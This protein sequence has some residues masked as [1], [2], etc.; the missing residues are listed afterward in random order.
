MTEENKPLHF[1]I[2][3]VCILGVVVAGFF[4]IYIG[5][6]I[7][8]AATGSSIT[9]SITTS[10]LNTSASEEPIVLYF[11]LPYV[12]DVPALPSEKYNKI[13]DGWTSSIV[14][15][16]YGDMLSLTA[17]TFP[18]KDIQVTFRQD[19][20]S[21]AEMFLSDR[22]PGAFGQLNLLP[23]ASNLHSP[24]TIFVDDPHVYRAQ[25]DADPTLIYLPDT[26]HS[27]DV[28][29]L[30]LM[31][32]L[33]TPLNLN[34]LLAGHMTCEAIQIHEHIPVD[35]ISGFI[36]VT[37]L[38]P[39]GSLPPKY[40]PIEINPPKGSNID[41]FVLFQIGTCVPGYTTHYDYVVG[42]NTTEL[43]VALTWD[44]PTYRMNLNLISPDGYVL[45]PYTDQYD[46]ISNGII[47]LTIT[48]RLSSAGEWG[49]EVSGGEYPD[50]HQQ[51][52]L[53][54]REY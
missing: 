23:Q 16:E 54:V 45:G 47:P 48:S 8:A 33:F 20:I 2:V 26:I 4:S 36:P 34:K 9:Y 42:T 10:G 3:V 51:Y 50:Q 14:S 24:Y 12:R 40:V 52:Q 53:H 31:Y 32:Q 18:L 35:S 22:T 11:P 49:I 28:V 46:R 37:P 7:W 38:I 27:A 25:P 43:L 30:H 6:Q 39:S 1:F 44:D 21:Y 13:L 5:S 15:T 19:Q 17:T 41:D 29:E